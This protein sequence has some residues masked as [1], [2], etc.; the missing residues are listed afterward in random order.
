MRT[1][2][3]GPDTLSNFIRDNKALYALRSDNSKMQI[4][5]SFQ[6]LLQ[7]YNIKSE[8]T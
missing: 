4:G 5:V 6:K 7:K 2:S 8:N 1:K 3:E